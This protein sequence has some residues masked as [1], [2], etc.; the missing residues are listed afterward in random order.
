MEGETAVVSTADIDHKKDLSSPIN[1]NYPQEHSRI[2]STNA[3]PYTNTSGSIRRPSTDER[4]TL[5]EVPRN[6]LN[7]TVA[8]VVSRE[9]G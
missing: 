9:L 8:H 6:P 3:R 2:S 5:P 7:A 4:H 1:A